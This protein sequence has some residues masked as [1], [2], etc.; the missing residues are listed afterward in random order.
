MLV[1]TTMA[2]LMNSIDRLILPTL[3]PAIM[4]EF[5]LT[6]IEAGFLNSLSFIGTFLGALILGFFSDYIGSGY[7]RCYSWVIAVA[8][9]I[10]AGVATAF[11]K[12]LGAFQALRIVM[13]FGSGGS[14]PINV[15]LI[16]EWWQKENR[17]FAIGLHH[18]GFPLGQFVGPVLIGGVIALTASWRDVFLFIP[19][20]GVPIIII[21]LIIATPKKQKKVYDWIKDNGMTVPI[22][23]TPVAKPTFKET[24]FSGLNCLKNR[25]C[26]LAIILFF[27]FIWAEM[28]IATF[29]TVH[30]TQEVGLDL[31]TAAV[32]SG[33]SGL[34]GWIGQIFW[35][36]YSDMKGRKICLGVIIVGWIAAAIACNFIVSVATGWIILVGWGLFRNSPFP[37]IYAFLIDSAPKAAASGMG[38]MIGIALGSAGFLVAPIAGWI[39][40]D[41][42][43]TTHYMVITAA[44][45]LS[46]IPL[47]LMKETVKQVA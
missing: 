47:F 29:L 1:V 42:G 44:L 9:E 37:V 5:N 10:G 28:G 34:T 32:I 40:A 23:E 14:E 38:L 6:T 22:D 25:N 16:G 11:C 20:L 2:I 46:C 7:K 35:G 21:Q 41:F 26:L 43:F 30:L 4:E 36:H 15:A 45:L 3:M 19:L 39:I 17:G 13:G 27:G 8:I 18:T 33:A 24:L 12:T 31:A